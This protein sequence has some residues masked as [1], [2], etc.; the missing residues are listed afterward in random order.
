MKKVK[1]HF[2]ESATAFLDTIGFAHQRIADQYQAARFW[3]ANQEKIV[4]QIANF[5]D[6]REKIT[7]SLLRLFGTISKAA[8]YFNELKPI[9]NEK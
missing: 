2:V 6:G 5:S 4:S 9:E 3:T 1:H 7:A 8:R